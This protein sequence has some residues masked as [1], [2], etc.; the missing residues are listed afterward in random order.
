MKRVLFTNVAGGVSVLCPSPEC[1]KTKSIEEIASKD[2][3]AGVDFW[4]VP[5]TDVSADR[6]FRNAWELDNMGTPSG[7]GNQSNRWDG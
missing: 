5:T 1:L 6:I 4:V 7:Q 3:P 2:V